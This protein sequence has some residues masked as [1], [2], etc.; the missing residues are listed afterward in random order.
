M[1]SKTFFAPITAFELFLSLRTG[2]H[3]FILDSSL[4]PL[5][6]GRLSFV[7]VDPF[8]IFRSKGEKISVKGRDDEAKQ[9]VG[10]P[11]EAL[12][13]LLG[14]YGTPHETSRIP[15]IGGAVGYLGYDLNRFTEKLPDI[16]VDDVDV[17]DC[18]FGFY[19]GIFVFDHQ[20]NLVTAFCLGLDQPEDEKMVL[21]EEQLAKAVSHR[22]AVLSYRSAVPVEFKSNMTRESYI[23]AI[24]RIRDYIRSGDIYQVNYTQRFDAPFDGDPIALYHALRTINPAPF[25]AYIDEGK[26]QV[27]SSSPERFLRVKNGIIET[28]PIKGTCPRGATAVEDE[29]NRR[30]LLVSEKDRAELLMIVDLE[31][32]DLG[33]IAKVGTVK[34]P[35]LFVVETYPTVHHLVS[36]IT[37]E[38]RPECDLIDCLKATFPGGS[39]TG[40]PKV[41]SMEIIEELEPTRRNVYTGALGYLGFNGNMDLNIVIRTLVVKDNRAYFQAGGAI[42]WDSDPD[43]EFEESILKAKALREAL[44]SGDR[45]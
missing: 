45:S 17:P 2:R 9:S 8:L 23:G 34:V 40:A 24:H 29:A 18:F 33:R 31:R 38:I 7:G 35:E 26:C 43:G 14:Q 25:S 22:P 36:T 32:N 6:L 13:S 1:R 4:D 27:L 42:T 15:F 12:R 41:R 28:R 10:D 3:P 44:S 11:F 37:A 19:D 39:I 20:Q 16:A 21:L 30:N 5:R